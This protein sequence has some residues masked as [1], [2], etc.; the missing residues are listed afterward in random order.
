MRPVGTTFYVFLLSAAP[1]AGRLQVGWRL[2]WGVRRGPSGPGVFEE[3]LSVAANLVQH[4][5]ELIPRGLFS[6]CSVY[7]HTSK[8]RTLRCS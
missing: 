5:V 1:Q 3:N 8:R 7:T 4:M 6:I 2:L